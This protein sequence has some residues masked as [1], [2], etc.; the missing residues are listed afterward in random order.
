LSY[1]PRA[2]EHHLFVAVDAQAYG[3]RDDLRQHDVQE[4]IDVM[5]DDAARRVGLPRDNWH[6]QPAGD[7]E[8][9]ILPADAGSAAASTLVD[10]YTRELAVA[11]GRHNVDHREDR[12]LRLRMAIH[13]GVA[14]PAK[15][16]WSGQGPVEVVRL[17]DCEQLHDLLV[18][19]VDLVVILS[20]SVYR[21]V[22]LQ[23]HTSLAPEDFVNV[24]ARS[25]GLEQPAYVFAPLHKPPWLP[26]DRETLDASR[27]AKLLCTL[28]PHIPP[29]EGISGYERMT[30]RLRALDY[31]TVGQV[32]SR[33]AEKFREGETVA[34]KNPPLGRGSTPHNHLSIAT[35]TLA[36]AD[37][38]FA[39]EVYGRPLE[40]E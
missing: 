39:I 28:Y 6:R 16:G 27:L 1:D 31:T 2:V 13:H 35:V 14:Q 36:L 25:K 11:L 12:R 32:R 33:I 29:A 30:K 17:R 37:P 23:R 19:P 22:V 15:L 38:D 34:A 10:D 3:G 4:R 9:A 40:F 20:Q 26:E 8:L 24:V 7:G 21:D 5:L 18:G